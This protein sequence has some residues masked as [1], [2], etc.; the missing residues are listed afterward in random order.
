MTELER[1]QAQLGGNP[2]HVRL[3][4]DQVAFVANAFAESGLFKTGFGNNKRSYSPQE[5]YAVIM[6]GQSMGLGPMPAMMSFHM[7]EGRP[8]M[9][10]N[11]QALF[12]KASPKYDYRMQFEF[13]EEVAEACEI[14]V[15]D[16]RTGEAIG[17]SRFTKKMAQRAGL[18]KGGSNWEKYAE[19]MLF[20]RAVSNA[21]AWHAPDAVPFRIYSEGETSG[22]GEA[23]GTTSGVTVVSGEEKMSPA[24]AEKIVETAMADAKPASVEEEVV[25]DAE[26]VEDGQDQ[27]A[28]APTT[29][30]ETSMETRVRADLPGLPPEAKAL[31]KKTVKDARKTFNFTSIVEMMRETDFEDVAP[32]VEYLYN[33]SQPAAGVTGTQTGSQTEATIS[34]AQGRMFHALVGEVGLTDAEKHLFL[35]KFAQANHTR[36]IKAKDFDDLLKALEDI[37]QGGEPTKRAYLGSE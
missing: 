5:C 31:I 27:A 16:K 13:V 19:S 23:A 2:R 1:Y 29:P 33:M 4:L 18:V 21:V 35:H 34:D 25:E 17:V 37:K 9:S 36:E 14:T 7:I 10:A 20:A 8:E 30:L 24:A 3:S 12:L 6:A 22:Q 28:A 26:V 32:W 15:F 11:L